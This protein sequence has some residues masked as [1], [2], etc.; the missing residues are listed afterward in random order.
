MTKLFILSIV[1]MLCLLFPIKSFASAIALDIKPTTIQMTVVKNGELKEHI[2]LTNTSLSTIVLSTSFRPF[3]A[4]SNIDGGIIY[5][6]NMVGLEKSV[7][8]IENNVKILENDEQINQITLA[9]KQQKDLIL[10]ISIKDYQKISDETFSLL[11]TTKKETLKQTGLPQNNEIRGVSNIVFSI[12]VNIL[13]SRNQT[14]NTQLQIKSFDTPTFIQTGPVS[15][16]VIIKNE[17]TKYINLY[18]KISLYNMLG[19]QVGTIRLKPTLLLRGATR[20]IEAATLIDGQKNSNTS[21]IPQWE[22]RFLLGWYTAR[23]DLTDEKG[24]PISN[25]ASLIFYALPFVPTIIVI[26]LLLI[27]TLLTRQVIKKTK[28]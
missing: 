24:N 9:P 16:S 28:E 21:S 1:F 27:F 8:F 7:E 18:S 2:L 14:E 20:T 4:S 3:R 26:V 5:P 23:L 6:A 13:L 22:R 12:P 10:S 11:L 15:F 17:A 19:Q 25:T